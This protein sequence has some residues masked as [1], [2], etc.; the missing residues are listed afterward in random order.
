MQLLLSVLLMLVIFFGGCFI[1]AMMI[2]GINF[3]PTYI[4]GFST[5][6]LYV[7]LFTIVFCVMFNHKNNTK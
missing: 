3:L 1:V 4:G 5:F 7:S 6:M 2:K